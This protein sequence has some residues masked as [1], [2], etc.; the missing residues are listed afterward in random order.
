MYKTDQNMFTILDDAHGRQT[1]ITPKFTF[2]GLR[3]C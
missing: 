2:L 1:N 3:D